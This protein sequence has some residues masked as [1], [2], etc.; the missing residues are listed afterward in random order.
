MPVSSF[1]IIPDII[2][3][4]IHKRPRRVLDLG[5]GN[6][7]YGALIRNYL[8]HVEVHGVEAWEGYEGPLWECYNDVYVGDISSVLLTDIG[9]F[10]VI[11]I[12]D[13][14]EHFTKDEGYDI[15]EAM[16]G[17]LKRGGIILMST[18]AV[19]IEQGSVGGND[20]EI[21]KSLWRPEDL[22][23]FD[24]LRTEFPDKYGHHMYLYKFKKADK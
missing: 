4:V 20:F 19:Y 10:N 3:E 12:A 2:N 7:M 9:F 16:K 18:P 17:R 1:A 5:I 6:G 22:P 8:P 21:H 24:Q 15:I 11:I 13:V 14:I 23:E